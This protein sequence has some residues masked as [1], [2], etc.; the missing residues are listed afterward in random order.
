[1]SSYYFNVFCTEEIHKKI[2]TAIR[3]RIKIIL[4]DWSKV[5]HKVSQGQ[6][7]PCNTGELSSGWELAITKTRRK[8]KLSF[9]IIFKESPHDVGSRPKLQHAALLNTPLLK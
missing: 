3:K 2:N 4:T 1:M 9:I 7:M 6:Y 5:P 8:L